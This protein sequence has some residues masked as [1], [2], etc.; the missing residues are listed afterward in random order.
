[1]HTDSISMVTA[2]E[3]DGSRP[4]IETKTGSELGVK[5]GPGFLG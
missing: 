3:P 2:I 4:G 1:M 5:V